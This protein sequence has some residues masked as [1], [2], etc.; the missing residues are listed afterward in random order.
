MTALYRKEKENILSEEFK[1]KDIL[2]V[3]ETFDAAPFLHVL[4]KPECKSL[5]VY[6][7]MSDDLKIHTIF[8]GVTEDNQD[9]L[10]VAVAGTTAMA[11]NTGGTE[12]EEQ[13]NIIIEEGVSCPPLCP[14]PVL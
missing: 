7:G 8:V 12:D 6:F 3:C 5:R 11:A 9:M 4:N 10:P 2:S 1:G 13:G 14:D